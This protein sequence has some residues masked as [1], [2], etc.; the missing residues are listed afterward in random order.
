MKLE[1]YCNGDLVAVVSRNRR[2]WEIAWPRR[3]WSRERIA[4]PAA[5]KLW[6]ETVL[7]GKLVTWLEIKKEP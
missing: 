2:D 1:A 5:A 6:V 7:H 4:D 3:G